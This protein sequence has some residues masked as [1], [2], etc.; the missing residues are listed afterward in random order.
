MSKS[1]QNK[2]INIKQG[3][4][5]RSNDEQKYASKLRRDGKECCLCIIDW[6]NS[7]IWSFI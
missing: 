1:L 3:Q 2:T 4:T 7:G 5:V 6:R